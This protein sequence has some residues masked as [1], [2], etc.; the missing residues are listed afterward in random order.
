MFAYLA[1]AIFPLVMGQ[2]YNLICARSQSQLSMGKKITPKWGYLFISAL[3]MFVLIG[4]R[5]QLIGPDT[6]GYL[7]N[8]E[9]LIDTPWNRIFEI[10]RW[11]ITAVSPGRWCVSPGR[12]SGWNRATGRPLSAAIGLT[13]SAIWPGR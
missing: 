5:H 4:F 10:S 1:V 2:L 3:P 8:F 11:P 7:H 9:L 6:G 12:C 13:R